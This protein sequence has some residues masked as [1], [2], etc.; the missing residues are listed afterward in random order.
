VGDADAH[1]AAGSG[2]DRDLAFEDAHRPPS[3]ASL[4]VTVSGSYC[5]I[6]AVGV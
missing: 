1:A 6:S 2:D 4:T 5:A 3:H